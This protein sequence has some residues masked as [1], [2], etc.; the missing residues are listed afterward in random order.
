MRALVILFAALMLAGAVS[1][2]GPASFKRPDCS[3]YSSSQKPERTC[4]REVKERWKEANFAALQK[5]GLRFVYMARPE[6]KAS[7]EAQKAIENKIEG[8]FAIRFSVRADGTVY[9]VQTVEVTEG[10]QPLAKLW[11]DTVGQ[12]TFAKT[13]EAVT[14]IEYRRIYMYAADDDLDSARRRRD[15]G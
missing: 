12:W 6:P 14:G 9:D 2:Q 7:R 4:V 10:I 1:A 15:E 11:A 3:A 8:S 5:T 13:R